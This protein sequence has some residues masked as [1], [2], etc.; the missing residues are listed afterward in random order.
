MWSY[1]TLSD[2]EIKEIASSEEEENDFTN[3]EMR[4]Q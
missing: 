3:D 2:M 4:H 1:T